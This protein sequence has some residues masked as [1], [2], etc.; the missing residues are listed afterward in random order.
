MFS[1]KLLQPF[2]QHLHIFLHYEYK[3]TRDVT[4]KILL[5]MKQNL[6]WLLFVFVHLSD[7]LYI[8]QWDDDGHE[9]FNLWKE[10][11]YFYWT[12]FLAYY[13]Y[14][15]CFWGDIKGFFTEFFFVRIYWPAKGFQLVKWKRLY[16]TLDVLFVHDVLLGEISHYFITQWND[17]LNCY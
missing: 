3:G 11:D 12:L 13:L 16:P 9:V 2:V 10:D 5:G 17:F 14:T 1:E 6:E 15:K 8:A 4:R 7:G